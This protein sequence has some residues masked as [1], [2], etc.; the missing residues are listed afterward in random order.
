[1]YA[2]L[3]TLLTNCLQIVCRI[4]LLSEPANA[5]SRGIC[6][7]LTSARAS[8]WRQ[9][10]N[11]HS[12]CARSYCSA[13]AFSAPDDILGRQTPGRI[14]RVHNQLRFGNNGGIIILRVI[15]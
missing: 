4:A 3:C 12:A 1:M 5:D 6:D 10:L 13:L 11:S 2:K 7:R 9:S 15:C 8:D 14:A